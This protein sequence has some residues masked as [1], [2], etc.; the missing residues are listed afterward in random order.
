MDILSI[1]NLAVGYEGNIVL[2]DVSVKSQEGKLIVLLGANGKGKSTLLKTL[3]GHLTAISGSVSIKGVNILKAKNIE[4][5]KQI[6]FIPSTMTLTQEVMVVDLLRFARIPYLKGVQKIGKRDAEVI[7]S[8]VNE[9]DIS[10]LLNVSY[11]SLSDGQKQMV[12]VARSL[13]Q[14]TSIITLDEPTAH[15]DIVNKQKLFGL[16]SKQAD[17]GKL[18]IC[19]TH[20]LHE[21]FDFAH[22]FWIIDGAGDFKVLNNTEDLT[23]LEIKKMLFD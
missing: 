2:K 17:N 10:S 16:L 8:V 11:V 6:S 13:I 12:N 18:V 20:D 14:E 19:S 22:E 3:V 9:L 23:E 7:N 4:L 5:A 15:L 1:E 21:S